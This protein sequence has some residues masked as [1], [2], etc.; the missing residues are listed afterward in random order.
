MQLTKGEI[1]QSTLDISQQKLETFCFQMI[2]DGV[3]NRILLA[4]SMFEVKLQVVSAESFGNLHIVLLTIFNFTIHTWPPYVTHS[5]YTL[6]VTYAWITFVQLYHQCFLSGR[7][8]Y[9]RSSQY[10]DIHS[11]AIIDTNSL[12]SAVMPSLVEHNCVLSKTRGPSWLTSLYPLQLFVIL[13][14]IWTIT[15]SQKLKNYSLPYQEVRPNKI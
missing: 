15:P 3:L 10:T 9:S 2:P 6:H 4:I 1:C 7:D 11:S 12:K 8:D 13:S 14:Q 5:G